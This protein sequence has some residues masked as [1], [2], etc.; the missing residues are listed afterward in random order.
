MSLWGVSCFDSN[1]ISVRAVCFRGNVSVKKRIIEAILR[2]FS[3]LLYDFNFNWIIIE[4]QC[5]F[6]V[7]ILSYK[8]CSKSGNQQ[9]K[10]SDHQ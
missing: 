10:L 7:N 3:E 6:S 8:P 5:F 2:V 4:N 9:G 1:V